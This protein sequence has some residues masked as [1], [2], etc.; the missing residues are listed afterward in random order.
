MQSVVMLC[1]NSSK[2]SRVPVNYEQTMTDNR[3]QYNSTQSVTTQNRLDMAD[4]P[5]LQPCLHTSFFCQISKTFKTNAQ[6]KRD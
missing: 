2:Q 3:T 1:I 4:L 5:Y 6:I